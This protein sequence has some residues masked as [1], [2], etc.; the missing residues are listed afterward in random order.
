M[1]FR[2]L[3]RFEFLS[4]KWR[5]NV[6]PASSQRCCRVDWWAWLEH[7]VIFQPY[8]ISG[9]SKSNTGGL[10]AVFGQAPWPEGE[11]YFHSPA[12]RYTDG[13]VLVDF[14]AESIPRLGG[15]EVRPRSQLCNCRFHHLTPEHDPSAVVQPHLS[16]HSV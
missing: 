10:S 16:R 5:S 11:T 9:N 7:C 3:P 12:G 1:R 6:F 14:L 4:R 8:S 13:R 2:S 15:L